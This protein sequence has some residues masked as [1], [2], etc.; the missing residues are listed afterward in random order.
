MKQLAFLENYK[1]NSKSLFQFNNIS[2][3]FDYFDEDNDKQI[4]VVELQKVIKYFETCSIADNI[5]L[6]TSEDEISNLMSILDVDGN[7]TVERQRSIFISSKTKTNY[8]AKNI[9]KYNQR[10]IFFYY[11]T[12]VITSD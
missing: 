11:K 5:Q 2:D 6:P 10:I 1:L 8:S 12:P 4:N 3:C 7:G 9:F